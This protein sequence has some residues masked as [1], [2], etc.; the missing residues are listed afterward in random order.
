MKKKFKIKHVLF[1]LEDYLSTFA[2]LIIFHPLRAF[3]K[4]NTFAPTFKYMF[5]NY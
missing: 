2:L 1:H 4:N 3:Q 5:L